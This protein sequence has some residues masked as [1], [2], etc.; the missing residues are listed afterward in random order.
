MCDTMFLYSITLC[1]KLSANP[2]RSV[3]PNRE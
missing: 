2:F 1:G 3:F